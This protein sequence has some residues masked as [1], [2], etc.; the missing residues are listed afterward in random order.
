MRP[1]GPDQRRRGPRRQAGFTLIELIVV[2]GIFGSVMAICY[3]IL[4]STMRADQRITRNTRSG[5]VGQGIIQQIRRDLQGAVWRSYGP[6][7]FIGIDGGEAEGAA[8]ELHFLTTA[9]VPSPEDD[10]DVRVTE[11]AGVGYV[12]KPGEDNWNTLFRRV[13]WEIA[14]APLDD[15]EYTEVY[16][17]VLALD[18]HYLGEAE[19]WLDEWDASTLLAELENEN[20]D[21]FLPFNDQEE[22][23]EEQAA[24][25]AAETGDPTALIDDGEEE[26]VEIPLPLPRAVEVVLYLGVGDERGPFLDEDGN[27][28]IERVSAIIPIITSEVIVVEDPNETEEEEDP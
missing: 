20:Y 12:L 10:F 23:D 7:V 19:E 24:L 27:P 16:G 13:K 17:L 9:P 22:A 26:E 14:D 5:K 6:E 25:D 8:D 11:V 21:T 1:Q 15:G 28:I 3:S 18:F 2:I 4:D